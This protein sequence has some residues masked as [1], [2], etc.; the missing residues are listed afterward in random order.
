[1]YRWIEH[2]AELEVEI[3]AG[4]RQDVFAE[5]LAAGRSILAT[6]RHNKGADAYREVAAG[7]AKKAAAS[8]KKPATKS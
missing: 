3:E 7:L 1:M 2:T 5:A 4:S 6:S 8:R